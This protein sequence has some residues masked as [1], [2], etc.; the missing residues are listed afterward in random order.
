[1]SYFAAKQQCNSR[2]D[3]QLFPPLILQ[4][5][6]QQQQMQPPQQHYPQTPPRAVPTQEYQQT[7]TI[8]NQVNLKKHTLRLEATAD[9]NVLAITFTC[10]ASAS[11]R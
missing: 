8:R 1:M 9:P 11:C 6:Q 4:S 5:G 2:P 3:M 7:A 10:D